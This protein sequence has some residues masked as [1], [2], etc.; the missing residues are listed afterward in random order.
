[1]WRSNLRSSTRHM[2]YRF[3]YKCPDI[4]KY[5]SPRKGDIVVFA[6]WTTD[7]GRD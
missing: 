3:L 7:N 1:M 2:M 4:V 5:S 6:R